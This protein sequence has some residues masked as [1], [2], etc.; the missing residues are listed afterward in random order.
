MIRAAGMTGAPAMRAMKALVAFAILAPLLAVAANA[1]LMLYTRGGTTV[2]LVGAIYQFGSISAGANSDV[3]FRV[4]NN[5]TSCVAVSTPTV[6]GAGFSIAAINGTTPYPLA[7]TNFIEFTVQFNDTTVGSYSAPLQVSGVNTTDCN[8]PSVN[9]INVLL[10]A[11][12]LPAP[13]ITFVSGCTNPTPASLNFSAVQGANDICNFNVQNPGTQPL[14]ISVTLTA[15]AAFQGPQGSQSPLNPGETRPFTITFTPVCGTAMYSGPLPG[16]TGGSLSINGQTF[17]LSASGTTPPLAP[18]INV[19]SVSASDQQPTLT[20]SLTTPS[21][22]GATGNLNL[23]FTPNV[24]GVADDSAV[25]FLQGNVRSQQFKVAPNSTAITI[26]GQSSTTFQTGTTAGAITFTITGTST[27][28]AGD[29]TA[30]VTIPP[31]LITIDTATASNQ[32][33]GQLNV[34]VIGF[35]NTY[36]AGVMSFTFFD[37]TGK[38]VG[39]AIDT[40]FT[41]Q[42]KSYFAGQNSGSAFL[43]NVSFPVLGNQALIGTV[44]VTLTNNAGSVQTGPLTFQ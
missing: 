26:G 34:E 18:T 39:S 4:L 2:T 43:M 29:P 11:T 3:I 22:C 35:D 21:L 14:P 41:S 5:G 6:A 31:A 24:P 42:F 10:L 27:P 25:V 36:S 16:G 15:N 1:Q 19:V 8:G 40:N 9:P 12:V 7:P 23:A 32:V 44:Q 38:Q 33:S 37:T 17:T 20:L 30:T 28:L 13:V